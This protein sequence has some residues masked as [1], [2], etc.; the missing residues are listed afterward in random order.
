MK[1]LIKYIFQ[2]TLGFNTYLFVFALYIIYTLRWN[3]NEK[4][5]L[6]FIKLIEK[7]GVIL[8]IGANIGV[9]TTYLAKH[10]QKSTIYSFEPVPYNLNVLRRIVKFFK[11]ENVRVMDFALGNKNGTVEMVMPVINNVKMQG[12]SHVIH[13]SIHDLN[14]GQKFKSRITRLDDLEEISNSEKQVVA[15]KIDVENFEYFV[16]EGGKKLLKNNNPILYM[17]LWANENRTNCFKLLTELGYEI[18]VLE[19]K[20]LTTYNELKHSTQN[21]FFNPAKV[22]LSK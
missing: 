9:M 15:I 5:F 8:D 17:E 18:K 11:L 1:N 6:Q 10:F 19:N 2:K 3:K 21:F 13:E 12:L 16:L 4:D 14:D 22:D 7:D 20:R